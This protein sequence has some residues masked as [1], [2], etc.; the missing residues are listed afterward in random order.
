MAAHSLRNKNNIEIISESSFGNPEDNTLITN[1]YQI[2]GV[3]SNGKY[4]IRKL[5]IN[6][7]N[8]DILEEKTG[9]I[10]RKKLQK[11]RDEKPPYQVVIYAKSSIKDIPYPPD[12]LIIQAS[13]QLPKENSLS[14]FVPF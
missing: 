9:R 2:A 12:S 11:I 14:G 8:G 5:R 7:Q 4:G 3:K 6:V 13:T 1:I 10:T